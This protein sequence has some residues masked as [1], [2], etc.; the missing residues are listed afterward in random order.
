LFNK[1]NETILRNKRIHIAFFALFQLMVFVAPVMIKTT[2]YHVREYSDTV[3]GSFGKTLSKAEKPCPICQ[4]EFIN[5][6]QTKLQQT[7]FPLPKCSLKNSDLFSQ[8]FQLS[9]SSFSHRAP[10]VFS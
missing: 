6:I 1:N 3:N 7:T 2:H 8:E 5:V 4:F 9:F 10:P